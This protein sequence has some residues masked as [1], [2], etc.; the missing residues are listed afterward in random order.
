VSQRSVEHNTFVIERRYDAPP[1]RVYT[2]WANPDAKARWFGG[3]ADM[4]ELDFRIGGRELNRGTA[5]DGT[6]VT[7]DARYEDIVPDERI[8]FTYYMLMGETRISVSVATVEIKNAGDGTHLAY[9][10][11]G[12]FLDGHDHPRQREAGTGGL[13]DALEKHLDELVA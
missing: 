8:V 12:A 7:Y 6:V 5:P 1:E 4:Y 11:Q 10:E 3:S 2:A 9:T 13:L